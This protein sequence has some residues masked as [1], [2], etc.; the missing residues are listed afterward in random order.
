MSY[1][2][3]IVD[4]ETLGDGST[5]REREII[6]IS[7]KTQTDKVLLHETFHNIWLLER[8][9]TSSLTKTIETSQL[10]WLHM[11]NYLEQFYN[12]TSSERETNPRGSLNFLELD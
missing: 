2:S 3:G 9:A 11:A 12:E 5:R 6:H 10:T 7:F 8:T 4:D 1:E